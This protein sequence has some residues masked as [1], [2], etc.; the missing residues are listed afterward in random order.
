MRSGG[1][2]LNQGLEACC[3]PDLLSL[4]LVAQHEENVSQEAAASSSKA[5]EGTPELS[6]QARAGSPHLQ[7]ASEL[8][9]LTYGHMGGG[10]W[11]CQL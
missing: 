4:V 9:P 1:L 6:V 10:G 11:E 5:P 2:R 8:P 7:L 3:E